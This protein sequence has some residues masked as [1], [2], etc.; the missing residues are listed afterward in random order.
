MT[1]SVSAFQAIFYQ[2]LTADRDVDPS[3][4]L[5]AF[6][7]ARGN[8]FEAVVFQWTEH[9]NAF[10]EPVAKQWL[11]ARMSDAIKADLKIV[12][13]LYAD[14]DMFSA[15]KVPNDLLEPYFLKVTEKNRVLA[16][17]WQDHI[18]EQA[19]IG[20]Y[21]PFEV[22]DRRWRAR[23]DMAALSSALKRDVQALNMISDLPV[24]ISSFFRGNATPAAY[25]DM[26][27]TIR[28]QSG[29]RFWVQDGS[30]NRVLSADERQLYLLPLHQC[31][32]SPVDGIVYEI[33][34]EVGTPQH[35]EANSLAKKQMRVAIKQRAPC[36]GDSVFFS[37]RYFYPLVARR[38]S[39]ADQAVQR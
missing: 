11:Q 20:W 19:L 38:Q 5:Q 4:W 35:F 3:V 24:Y 27:S 25:E 7:A 31:D 12:V 6:Q 16:A 37:L 2:P 9:G 32:Q 39:S 28:D 33:F 13:G 14:A 8:G 15:V 10:E 29:V 36:G 23:A 17:F 30:G 22:D 26:L 18:P 34:R 1:S 21:L